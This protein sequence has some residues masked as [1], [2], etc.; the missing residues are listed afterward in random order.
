MDCT[1]KTNRFHMPLLDILD[2]T[3]LHRTFFAAF[4]KMPTASRGCDSSVT[5]SK[6]P[7][8]YD[9]CRMADSNLEVMCLTRI[10]LHC[11]TNRCP[12]NMGSELELIT[13]PSHTKSHASGAL[14]L[15]YHI[16]SSYPVLLATWTSGIVRSSIY[17]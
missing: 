9:V 2:S 10:R 13:T 1:Y 5:I 14:D 15:R 8:H 16:A 6:C 3:G 4:C 7:W 12:S 11:R 17:G